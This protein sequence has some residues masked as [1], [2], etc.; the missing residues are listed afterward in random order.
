MNKPLILLSVN[1]CT[2]ASSFVIS[3]LPIRKALDGNFCSEKVLEVELVTIL[4]VKLAKRTLD[5]ATNRITL[6][7]FVVYDILSFDAS[8]L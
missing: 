6:C 8:F 5:I 2:I 7:S 4:E 1:S 3:P